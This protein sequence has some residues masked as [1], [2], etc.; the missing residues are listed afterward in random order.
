[1]SIFDSWL[2]LAG[3]LWESLCWVVLRGA[4]RNGRP[5]TSY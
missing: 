1:L 2:N 3:D 4:N 5:L